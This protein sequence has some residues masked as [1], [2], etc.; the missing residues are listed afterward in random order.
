MNGEYARFLPEALVD[1]FVVA[2]VVVGRSLCMEEVSN[3][4]GG[5]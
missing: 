4:V 2:I 1:C 5:V 3:V